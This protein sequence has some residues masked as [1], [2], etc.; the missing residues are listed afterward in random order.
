ME[1]RKDLVMVQWIFK[2]LVAESL[3]TMRKRFVYDV[4]AGEES[5]EPSTERWV[6]GTAQGLGGT[7]QGLSHGQMNF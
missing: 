1:R 2:L 7:E 6:D 3:Q 5:L 4:P